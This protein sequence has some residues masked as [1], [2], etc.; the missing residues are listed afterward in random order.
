MIQAEEVH[1]LRSVG[2]SRIRE[3]LELASRLAEITEEWSGW[4]ECAAGLTNARRYAMGARWELA[5]E[6]RT[7]E[8]EARS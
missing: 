2:L 5:K 3:A 1:A 7:A 6:L 8:E 4:N